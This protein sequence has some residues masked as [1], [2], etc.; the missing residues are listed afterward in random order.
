MHVTSAL[1][2]D[3]LVSLTTLLNVAASASVAM[4]QTS[5]RGSVAV[6]RTPA[7]V[8]SSVCNWG[9]TGGTQICAPTWILC[10]VAT[11]AWNNT[12]AVIAMDATMNFD[13]MCFF[14]LSPSRIVA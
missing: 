10:A 5:H 2:S 4:G 11:L 12:T 14:T 8:Y 1:T 9:A 13:L 7:G 3:K 6:L